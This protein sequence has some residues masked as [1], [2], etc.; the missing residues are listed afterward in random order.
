MAPGGLLLFVGVAMLSNRFARP[1]ASVL[2]RPGQQVGGV[3]GGLARR[4]AMR[5]PSRTSATAAAL[6]I[7]V[8][9]VTFVA[10]FGAGIK[11]A[12]RSEIG[13][14]IAASYVVAPDGWSAVSAPALDTAAKVP[15]VTTASGIVQSMAK[16]GKDKVPVDGVDTATVGR[17]LNYT[18]KDG[19]STDVSKLGPRDALVRDEFAKDHHLKVGSQVD[20][21]VAVGQAPDGDRA[22]DRE[23]QGAER[24]FRRRLHDPGGG[25][26]PHVRPARPAPGPDR[27]S[28]VGRAGAGA[29]AGPFPDVKLQGTKAYEDSRLSGST[30]CWRSSTSS[31]R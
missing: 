11:S 24:E 29:G 15:G 27:R 21:R 8:S 19:A 25:L 12:A 4:N 16:V 30:A 10:V 7:G 31:W 13:D 18:F 3:A 14:K 17:V 6:M 2:G 28:V 23:D 26:R 9:L 20:A 22:R 1:L 5:N